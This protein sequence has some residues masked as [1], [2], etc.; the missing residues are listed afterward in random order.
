[1]ARRRRKKKTDLGPLNT[2][3]DIAGAA[4][5]GAFVKHKIKQDYKNGHGDESI[6]AAT[7]V[8]GHGAFRRGTAGTLALGGLYGVNSAIRDIE[9]SE[10]QSR[11]SKQSNQVRRISQ[12]AYD[13]GIDLSY[14]KTNDNRYAWR[15]NCEDGAPYGIDP[16]DYETRDAYHDA[17]QK[18]KGIDNTSAENRLSSP[19]P[20]ENPTIKEITDMEEHT[21]CRVS[22][23]DNGENLYYL[24]DGY[25]L[26]IGD[27][28]I[29]S[30]NEGI[31]V[32]AVVLSVESHT[33]LTA[34]QAPGNTDNI[35]GKA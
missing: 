1:M 26:R 27:M 28:V 23:L 18:A 15:L 30:V 22:R 3:I 11:L 8:Y 31:E 14:Y 25:D 2:M 16:A 10:Q 12:R 20:N 9:R 35:L 4:A 19:M 5:M 34:P 6:R 24:A 21:Y 29:L 17:I 32:K 13:D 33:A 7:M